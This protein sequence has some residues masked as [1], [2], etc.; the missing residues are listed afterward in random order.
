MIADEVTLFNLALNA[1]GAR[2][3]LAATNERDRGAEVCTL[4]LPVVRDAVLAAAP[5]P[6]CRTQ[7]RLSLLIERDTAEDWVATD[8]DPDFIYAYSV[9]SNMVQPSYLSRYGRFIV[10]TRSAGGTAGAE[11]TIMTNEEDAILT[12]TKRQTVT[13]MWEDPLGMAIAYAL[14]AH[15]CMPLT[16]KPQ[17]AGMLI[18][19]ANDLINTARATAANMSDAPFESIPDWI[20]ARG[21]GGLTGTRYFYPF[22]SLLTVP[23]VG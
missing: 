3:N 1:V 21:Y 20:A 4:W 22:G 5:W 23:N 15:I 6:S 9:P 16:G 2:S 18:Q 12:Y 10:G 19:M 7:I 14:G 8:P 13:T 17:R 11:K